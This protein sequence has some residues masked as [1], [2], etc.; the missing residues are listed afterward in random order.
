M[1]SLRLRKEEK[2]MLKLRTVGMETC[3]LV[4]V[5]AGKVTTCGVGTEIMP[6]APETTP[7]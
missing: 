7:D 6:L 4:L 2:G 5:R 3:I 1:N